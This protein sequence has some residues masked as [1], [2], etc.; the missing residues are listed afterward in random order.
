MIRNK[1]REIVT[2]QRLGRYGSILKQKEDMHR[3]TNE[4]QVVWDLLSNNVP[5]SIF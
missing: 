3:K 2:D 4:I 5:M 1:D